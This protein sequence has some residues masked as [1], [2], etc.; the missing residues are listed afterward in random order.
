M[1]KTLFVGDLHL[2]NIYASIKDFLELLEQVKKENN[3]IEEVVFVGDFIDGM[4]KYQTQAYK[5]PAESFA[6]QREGLK[7]L[8]ELV[9][10]EIGPKKLVFVW[11]NHE[12]DFRGGFLDS[13]LYQRAYNNVWFYDKYIDNNKLL[14]IH[15][16]AKSIYVNALSGWSPS[17]VY[18]AI[19]SIHV[20]EKEL[21]TEIRGVVM[22][23]VHK[24]LD[25]LGVSNKLLILL[26]S[27]LKTGYEVGEDYIYQP[28]LVLVNG[29]SIKL[30]TKP[31]SKIQDVISFNERLYALLRTDRTLLTTFNGI[32]RNI[33]ENPRHIDYTIWISEAM[34]PGLAEAFSVGNQVW[35][36]LRNKLRRMS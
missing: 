3:D 14:V 33:Q 19:E 26:P 1:G 4:D 23:H 7:W 25:V 29:S 9:N 8:I 11:G 16:V 28:A 12:K 36:N 27:F 30:Y 35:D 2:G 32:R 22:G 21:E 17:S 20:L 31:F 6:V 15:R 34:G 5:Q 18:K 24:V 13:E 10:N